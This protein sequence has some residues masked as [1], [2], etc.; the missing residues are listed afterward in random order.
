MKPDLLLLD[1]P[2]SSLDDEAKQQGIDLIKEIYQQWQIPI[3]FV[4]HSKWEANALADE[5]IVIQ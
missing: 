4:T 5:T 1:E 3:I 2:F